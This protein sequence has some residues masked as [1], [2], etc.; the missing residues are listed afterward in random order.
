MLD[1]DSHSIM[2]LSKHTSYPRDG[3]K[4]RVVMRPTNQIFKWRGRH[5]TLL[6]TSDGPS[7]ST[8]IGELSNN[9]LSAVF[10]DVVLQATE[11]RLTQVE[12]GVGTPAAFFCPAGEGSKLGDNTLAFSTCCQ[13]RSE[14]IGGCLRINS[15]KASRSVVIGVT[16][17]Q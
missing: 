2:R 16:I 4:E 12:A 15:I 10:P 17:H 1:E 11:A 7:E 9:I 6:D 3:R 8:T 14:L 13:N 5:E